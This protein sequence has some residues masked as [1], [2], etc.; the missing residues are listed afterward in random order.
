[1]SLPIPLSEPGP[2]LNYIMRARPMNP[3]QIDGAIAAIRAMLSTQEGAIFL[4]MLE[5]STLNWRVP[6]LA[7]DRALAARN[8]QSFIALDLR[9]IL[10]DET[11]QLLERQKGAERT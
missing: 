10:S 7:D 6:V 8:A 4:E 11:E 3:K 1:M 2:L 9:R 5:N